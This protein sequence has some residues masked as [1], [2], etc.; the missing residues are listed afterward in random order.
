[1]YGWCGTRKNKQL[2]P[3]TECRWRLTSPTAEPRNGALQ[4]TKVSLP[5]PCSP[6]LQSKKA[7]PSFFEEENEVVTYLGITL[8]GGRPV[9]SLSANLQM[10]SGEQTRTY[11]K[12]CTVERSDSF[13]SLS[14]HCGQPQ[15]RQT[16]R[17]WSTTEK[18]NQQAVV[19]HSKDK[20]AGCGQPQQRQTNRLWSTTEKTNQQAVVNHSKDKPTGSWKRPGPDTSSDHWCDAVPADHM[21]GEAHGSRTS[22]EE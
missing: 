19:N 22:N 2:K 6:C 14:P 3:H 15:Q 7:G 1:M 17:L 8:T 10:P 21:N 18:T 12:Q 11:W 9:G 4:L 16:N 13:S 5:P 20:P